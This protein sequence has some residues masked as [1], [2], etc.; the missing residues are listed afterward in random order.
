MLRILGKTMYHKDSMASS[1]KTQFIDALSVKSI[2][3]RG[4]NNSTIPANRVLVTDGNG[5][6]M[7]QDMNA[8]NGGGA[9]TQFITTPSTFTSATTNATFSI[10]N[11]PN[12]GLRSTITANTVQLYAN[13]YNQINLEGGV[14]GDLELSSY[15]NP[16]DTFKSA[17]T[18]V[19][20]SNIAI[21]G[22]AS[23]NKL[24]F[25]AVPAQNAA[26]S[27]IST[28][29]ANVSSVTSTIQ[30][31][32]QNYTSPYQNQP[33]IQYG[34]GLLDNTGNA[35][36]ALS[37]LSPPGKTYSTLTSVQLTYA[38]ANYLSKPSTP[39][40]ALINNSNAFQ[41]YGQASCAFYWTTYG[42][43]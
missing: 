7:W 34:S 14:T 13:A 31:K 20:G 27:T 8:L 4:A 26:A 39:I 10:I 29:I 37:A 23:G 30:Y 38:T 21:V 2:Y 28:M 11:G 24:S 9:F 33:F 32:T 1:Q 36:I 6:T 22:D 5:G 43:F 3:A 17:L 19:A 42:M 40:M 35:T 41:A 18:F 25:S 16:T 15:D 12:A